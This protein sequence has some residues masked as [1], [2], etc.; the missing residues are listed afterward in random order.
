MTHL[1]DLVEKNF[2]EV[3]SKVDENSYEY[4]WATFQKVWCVPSVIYRI[5]MYI[6]HLESRVRELESHLDDY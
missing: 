1:V 6:R 5:L 2:K 4:D 3:Q